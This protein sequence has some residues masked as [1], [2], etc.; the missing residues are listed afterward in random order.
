M[1]HD[2][3]IAL[4][5]YLRVRCFPL[6]IRSHAALERWQ[7][8]RLARWLARD[9]PKVE[10]FRDRAGRATG[11]D[12]LPMIGKAE[13]MADF[14]RYN[15]ARISNDQGWHAFATDRRIGDYIVG[16]STGTSGNRGLFVIS[17]RERF[18]WLGAILAK[19]LPD[20][21]RHHDRVA[22][23]LPIDT[24]LYDSANRTRR[25]TLA[26]FDISDPLETLAPQLEAFAPSVLIAPPRI[27]RRLVELGLRLAP[28][29]VF[30]AAEMLEPFDRARIEQ[31]FGLRLD[32]IYMATEGLLGVS[33]AH[34]R[35]HLAEDCLHFA[36][37]PAGGGLVNPI[38][39][40]FSRT[41][42]IMA[43]YRM[44]DLLRL[45]DRPCP[46]GAPLRVVHEIVGRQDDVF[47]LPSVGGATVEL[48]PDILRNTVI[49]TDRGIADFQLV[50]TG[51]A[52]VELHLPR[53]CAA[54]V[55]QAVQDNLATLF[56]RHGVLPGTRISLSE[57]VPHATGKLR[58]VR[59]DWKP[60]E[61]N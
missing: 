17:Q 7:A 5:S 4:A 14:S 36:F 57:P 45:D 29:R 41:T 21:W 60:E 38:I 46:C 51:A 42:Q 39:T 35:L 30:S 9:L 11:L 43:R 48:T 53:D 50:Q 12:D 28:R 32:Q 24:P 61:R 18:A 16:A 19:A 6:Q 54:R 22:V 58:R 47:R 31:G 8:R 37:E 26:F 56:A 52:S 49:D 3:G 27:L 2:L 13:L 34:G 15:V 25:L 55:G 40:D 33:C 10:A 20:F 44:N 23:L 59:R 1:S